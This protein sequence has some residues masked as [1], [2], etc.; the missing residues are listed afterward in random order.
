MSF[1][2]DSFQCQGSNVKI[3][4]DEWT[5][6]NFILKPL[7]NSKNRNNSRKAKSLNS[8]MF[9]FPLKSCFDPLP[10]VRSHKFQLMFYVLSGCSMIVLNPNFGSWSWLLQLISDSIFYI[11]GRSPDAASLVAVRPT[12]TDTSKIFLEKKYSYCCKINFYFLLVR[13]KVGTVDFSQQTQ[14]I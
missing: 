6:A 14:H 12:P 5:D 9:S 3:V 10:K 8:S 13:V 2:D 11:T 1:W 7:Q 4:D